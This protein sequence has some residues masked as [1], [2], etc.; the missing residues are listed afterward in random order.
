MENV[1]IIG[2]S[3]RES[4]YSHKAQLMLREHGHNV[5]P[6]N[7]HGGE[8]LGETCYTCIDKIEDH[9]DTVTLYVSPKRLAGS[10][11]KIIEA[12]P[13]RVIFNPGTESEELMD[14][15]RNAGIEVLTACTLVLLS[16]NQF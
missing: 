14:T 16:T 12:K 5:Y 9:I 2:A 1:A 3:S 4:R 7:P 13:K 11:D 8:V 15:V 6:V 10:L